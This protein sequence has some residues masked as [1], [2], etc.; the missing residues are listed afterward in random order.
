MIIK[1]RD[2]IFKDQNVKIWN[3]RKR[4]KKKEEICMHMHINIPT[5]KM[6]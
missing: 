5:Y 6:K 2:Y 3:S 1:R 4:A